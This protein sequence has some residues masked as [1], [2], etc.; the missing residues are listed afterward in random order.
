M[1]DLLRTTG[2]DT[3]DTAGTTATMVCIHGGPMNHFNRHGQPTVNPSTAKLVSFTLGGFGSDPA[4][5][6][7]E[8]KPVEV[9]PNEPPPLKKVFTFNNRDLY[10]A[11]V[12]D[13]EAYLLFVILSF[14]FFPIVSINHHL[15]CHSYQL[16]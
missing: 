11:N 5:Q 14:R 15:L 16:C 10:C 8:P 4:P 13:S 9:N 7:E 6:P 12:G 2:R 3:F 1:D